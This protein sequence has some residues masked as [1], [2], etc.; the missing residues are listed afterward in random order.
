SEQFNNNRNIYM[1]TYG[2]APERSNSVLVKIEGEGQVNQV[3]LQHLKPLLML[4]N[5]EGSLQKTDKCG[6]E[7]DQLAKFKGKSEEVQELDSINFNTFQEREKI[8]IGFTSS[9][10]LFNRVEG[11]ISTI[12][13]LQNNNKVKFECTKVKVPLR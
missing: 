10:S 13:N 6:F 8:F 2:V 12:S 4:N 1:S 3:S 5:W 11:T 7:Q 9:K